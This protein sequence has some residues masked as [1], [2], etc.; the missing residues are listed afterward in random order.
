MESTCFGDV[1]CDKVEMLR[2]HITSHIHEPTE[3]ISESSRHL[4]IHVDVAVTVLV[5]PVGVLDIDGHFAHQHQRHVVININGRVA[6]Y[7]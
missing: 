4:M 5:T 2:P 3:H 1:V 6:H 7:Y